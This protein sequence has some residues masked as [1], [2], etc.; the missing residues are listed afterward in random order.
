[1]HDL[2]RAPATDPTSIYR[3]RDGL[4][5]ADLLTAALVHL[6]FFT[7]LAKKPSSFEEICSGLETKPRPTDVM[8]T[9]FTAM[10]YIENR[11]GK[12]QV[13]A[14]GREHLVKDSPFFIGPYYASLKDRPVCKDML[15]ALKNDRVANWGSFKDE[16]AWAKAMEDETFAN[17][18]TA[19]M[20]CRGVHLGQALAKAVNLKLRKRLLDIGGGSGIYSCSF[21]AHFPHLETA[22]FEKPPVDK[23]AARAIEKRGY[24]ERVKVIAGDMFKEA[25]PGGF[26]AHLISN[27][28]HDWDVPEVRR[29]LRASHS[30]LKFGGML[31]VHDAYINAEKTGP[32]PV[33][34]YSTMLMHSTEGKCYS[35]GEMKAFLNELGYTDF[36][37]QTTA[38]DRGFVSAI[39]S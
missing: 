4:Y 2:L 33:A 19:A 25:L 17:G 15:S 13:T 14:L 28:L 1:M 23:V 18:F 9:L 7:W 38:A 35:V 39:K 37:F 31:I 22:V 26:D 32:L 30:A 10:G 27:V 29:I 6:D 24:S 21:A 8:L 12:F 16:Q 11:E 34:A 36:H 20:D 3:Y 5:A